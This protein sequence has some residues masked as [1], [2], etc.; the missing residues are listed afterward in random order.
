MRTAEHVLLSRGLV[1]QVFLYRSFAFEKL[2]R[3]VLA[4]VG[5]RLDQHL[6]ET[7][8]PRPLADLQGE[9][10]QSFLRA[11][12][13]Q[14]HQHVNIEAVAFLRSSE[15]RFPELPAGELLAR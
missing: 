6:P 9:R 12:F 5:A 11:L 3:H 1:V 8:R 13:V 15:I 10:I 4:Q 14:E 7:S 2:W